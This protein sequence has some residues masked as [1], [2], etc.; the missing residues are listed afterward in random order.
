[1]YFFWPMTQYYHQQ[2]MKIIKWDPCKSYVY[3]LN[4]KLFFILRLNIVKKLSV[5]HYS[6]LLCTFFIYKICF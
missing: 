4:L 5:E 3:M 1:M 6:A 2:M